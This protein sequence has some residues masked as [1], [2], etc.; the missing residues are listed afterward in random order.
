MTNS[1]ILVEAK[2]ADDKWHTHYSG[3]IFN[4]ATETMIRLRREGC[5]GIRMNITSS[6]Q[7]KETK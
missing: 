5:Q 7:E 3:E 2:G 1:N 4:K 6:T